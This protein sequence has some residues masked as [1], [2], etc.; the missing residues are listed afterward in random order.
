MDRLVQSVGD[1]ITPWIKYPLAPGSDVA[2][3]VVAVGA[4]VTRFGVGDRV[5]GYAAGSDKGHRAAQG[6]FQAY[7]MVLVN[8]ASPIPATLSFAAA[9]VL[10]LALSTAASGLFEQDCLAL[11]RPSATP[12]ATGKTLLIWGG[13]TS[14]GSNAVH[15][16]VAA[17]YD[18]IT[19]ASPR[20]FDHVSRLGAR[21]AF[22][23]RSKTVV[24]DIVK[25][26]HGRTL[27][28]ALAIGADSAARCVDIVGACEGRRFVAMATP[29]A[30]FDHVPAGKGRLWRLIRLW[31]ASSPAISRLRSR[32]AAKVSAPSSSGAA[33]CSTPMSVR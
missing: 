33:R 1:L 30:S 24:A 23:Y 31:R 7:A 18:V 11:E 16:A 8:M 2:G 25:A 5:L 17:G 21:Q 14:V 20:N 13:S 12:R 26:L 22:D 10:P 6:A 29:P 15:L 32:P 9:S 19:T 28:G 27:A 4:G 3:E